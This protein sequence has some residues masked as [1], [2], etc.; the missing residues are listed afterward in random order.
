MTLIVIQ[1]FTITSIQVVKKPITKIIRMLFIIILTLHDIGFAIYVRMY[2][3]ENRTGFMGHLCGALAGLS[4]GIFILDSRRV[5]TWEPLVQWSCLTLFLLFIGGAIVWN[6][7]G[8][9][10]SPGKIKLFAP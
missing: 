6:F 3:P 2:D 10:R 1:L 9:Q 4:I 5:K 8:D 7:L